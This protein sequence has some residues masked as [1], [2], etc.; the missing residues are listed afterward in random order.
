VQAD[1]LNMMQ[2]DRWYA[3]NDYINKRGVKD[4]EVIK[5]NLESLA[6][7]RK[8]KSEYANRERIYT[9]CKSPK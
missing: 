2:P 9:L 5:A 8:I 7:K 1:I 4:K 6:K 3:V